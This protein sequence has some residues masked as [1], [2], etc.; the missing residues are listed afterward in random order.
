MNFNKA[1]S[2]LTQEDFNV[3]IQN[4]KRS[5]VIAGYEFEGLIYLS[6]TFVKNI[7][8][9]LLTSLRFD[10]L[11]FLAL[12]D[13]GINVF[14]YEI[15]KCSAK[16]ILYFTC[17]ISDELKAVNQMEKDYLTSFPDSKMQLAGIDKLNKFGE[18]NIIDSLAGGDILK[19]E[20]IR[21]LPYHVIFDKQ[22][23][24]LTEGAIQKSLKEQ[25][26]PKKTH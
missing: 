10:R 13:K 17:W 8:P 23:K 9:D 3:I 24:S 22:L 18:M 19:H 21:K 14:E 25:N 20:A 26:K 12:K 15:N 4:G 11:A 5:N 7:L 16:E 6:Y 2:G 1:L